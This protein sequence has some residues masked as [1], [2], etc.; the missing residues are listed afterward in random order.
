MV[1]V[2]EVTSPA[3]KDRRRHADEL[4][5]KI[6]GLLVCG[7]HALLIDS[8]PPTRSDPRGIHGAVWSR[9][10]RRRFR[11]AA[12]TPL[13]LASYQW[14]GEE[15]IAYLEA[16]AVGRPLT[17]MPLFLPDGRFVNVP[18]EETYLQAYRGVGEYWREILD[19]PPGVS[20]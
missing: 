19:A 1:A 8:L 5:D 9:F 17:P 6:A 15:P 3:N 7:V 10:E 2:I 20:A 12:D 14:D 11:P 16:T 18:L 13:M 4:A